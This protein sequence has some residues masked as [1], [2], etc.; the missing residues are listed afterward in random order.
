MECAGVKRRREPN[1]AAIQDQAWLA[2]RSGFR[3][4]PSS[5][6]RM[7]KSSARARDGR[8]VKPQQTICGRAGS[9]SRISD[10]SVRAREGMPLRAGDVARLDPSSVITRSR[11][12]T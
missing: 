1:I 11:G 4:E 6:P 7:T 12:S 8:R 3:P 9:G 10:A 2:R 5:G